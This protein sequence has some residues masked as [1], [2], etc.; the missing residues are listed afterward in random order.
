LGED[1]EEAGKNDD[2]DDEED[3]EAGFDV[4]MQCAI[5]EARSRNNIE[6]P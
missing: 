5:V 3:G 2:E 4:L 6:L 1:D